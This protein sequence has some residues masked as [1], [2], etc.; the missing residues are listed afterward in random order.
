MQPNTE[1][2]DAPA[3]TYRFSDYL[4]YLGLRCFA[5]LIQIM[6]IERCDRMCRLMARLLT[7]WIPLRR[8]LIHENLQRV[9][10]HWDAAQIR[11]VQREMWH[12]LLLMACEVVQAPRKI[13]R[14]NW[15]SHFT[16]PDRRQF[17]QVIMDPRPVILVSGHFGNFELASFLTGLFGLPSTTIARPLDNG[18]VHDYV[19]GIRSLGGQ[20]FLAKEGSSTA[21]QELLSEGGT[22]A[23]LADQHGGSKGCW[24]DF[25]GHPASCHKG[26]A[27]FR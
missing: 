21:V 1:E 25:L 13:H 10:P 11:R 19:M 3:Q 17:V 20:H 7:D 18:Y 23:L 27:L 16:I 22:L 14:E 2:N 9:F 8:K 4:G 12:H 15:Q 26:L 5:S 24:V 6:S